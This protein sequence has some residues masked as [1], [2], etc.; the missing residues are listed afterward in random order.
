LGGIDRYSKGWRWCKKC[1]QMYK[2][3]TGRCPE[4]HQLRTGPKNRELKLKFLGLFDNFEARLK[5]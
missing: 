1:G 2:D 5:R 4:G 3:Y